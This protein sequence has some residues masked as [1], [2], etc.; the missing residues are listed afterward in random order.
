MSASAL[1][2]ETRR[3]HSG[4]SAAA[5]VVVVER[6]RDTVAHVRSLVSGAI[7]AMSISMLVAEGGF[8]A[9]ALPEGLL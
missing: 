1:M 2:S 6:I 4:S 7:E 8:S 3:K 5:A 9:G